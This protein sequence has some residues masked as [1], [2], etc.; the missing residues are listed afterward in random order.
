MFLPLDLYITLAVA[1]GAE[2]TAAFMFSFLSDTPAEQL[3]LLQEA[4]AS[5]PTANTACPLTDA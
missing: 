4:R 2:H 3:L 1:A 5:R